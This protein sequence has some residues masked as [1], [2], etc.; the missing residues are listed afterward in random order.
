MDYGHIRYFID[1]FAISVVFA[2]SGSPDPARTYLDFASSAYP[3]D[4]DLVGIYGL[5]PTSGYACILCGMAVRALL[6][7]HTGDG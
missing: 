4:D 7:I 3:L 5:A 6:W 1:F 2:W